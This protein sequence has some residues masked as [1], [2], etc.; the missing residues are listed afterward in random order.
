MRIAAI[1]AAP[2][3]TIVTCPASTET[4]KI[5]VE[6]AEAGPSVFT[7]EPVVTIKLKPDSRIAFGDFTTARRGE[8]V[9]MRLG[10]T[11]LYEPAIRE[12]IL[13]GTLTISGQLT[14]QGA[15]N[16]AEAIMTGAA[17]FEVDGSDK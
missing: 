2:A 11:V 7:G 12:P 16:L 14:Q 4:L 6:R 8:Q 3:T 9:T 10:Q 13:E 17:A 5:A 15:R 1:G